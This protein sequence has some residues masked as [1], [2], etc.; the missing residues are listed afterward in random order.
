MTRKRVGS[1][2]YRTQWVA[3]A[4]SQESDL[5]TQA[6]AC[7]AT[8]MMSAES[9]RWTVDVHQGPSGLR[10]QWISS[11]GTAAP[12]PIEAEHLDALV[13]EIQQREYQ[14]SGDEPDHDMWYAAM[15]AACAM[16]GISTQ[17]LESVGHSLYHEWRRAV[18]TSPH[19][20][21]DLLV[22]L[23]GNGNDPATDVLRNPNCP[24]GLVVLSAQ[25]SRSGL[26]EAAVSNPKCPLDVIDEIIDSPRTFVSTRITIANLD[27]C[28]PDMLQRLSRDPVA[29]VRQGVARHPKCPTKVLL[30]LLSDTDDG[31]RTTALA[32]PQCPP[33]YQALGKLAH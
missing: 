7:T 9:G 2:Q 24:L 13:D 6:Q 8:S 11:D 21:P 5:L 30:Q 18:A 28:T 3:E 22:E 31:V 27:R 32:N 33:E 17:T 25:S 12:A 1:N 14:Y 15:K 23:C 16:P 20:P 19:T 10:L 4:R 26:Q 29:A